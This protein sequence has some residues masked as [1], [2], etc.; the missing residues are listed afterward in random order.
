MRWAALSALLVVG[1]GPLP[2]TPTFDRCP[3]QVSLLE[4]GEPDCIIEVAGPCTDP[5]GFWVR[6][7]LRDTGKRTQWVGP[8]M[9]G[10]AARERARGWGRCD[11]LRQS[12]GW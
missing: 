1:C 5:E 7:V 6:V 10:D 2:S 11:E 4:V 8:E 12:M 9:S 3:K